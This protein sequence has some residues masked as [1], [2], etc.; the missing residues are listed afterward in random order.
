M[1]RTITISPRKF[2]LA[3]LLGLV[4]VATAGY[5]NS[6]TVPGSNAGDGQSAISGYVVSNVHYT[7]DTNNPSNVTSL[8]FTLSPALPAGGASRISLN[9]GSNWLAANACSGTSSISCNVSASVTSLA[10]LR[11]VA[12]Q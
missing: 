8:S 1:N 7:L 6:N 10:N 4:S 3:G 9:G 11:V 12:A 2:V 5:A